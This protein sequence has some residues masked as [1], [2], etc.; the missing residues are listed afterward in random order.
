MLLLC[1][2]AFLLFTPEQKPEPLFVLLPPHRAF[3]YCVLI[4]N[5]VSTFNDS[6]DLLHFVE[7]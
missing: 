2:N 7:M 6:E 3:V 1:T 5:Q 4:K